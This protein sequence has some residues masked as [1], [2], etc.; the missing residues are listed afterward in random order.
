MKQVQE[1]PQ[2]ASVSSGGADRATPRPVAPL[3]LGKLNLLRVGYLVM[4]LGLVV[5]KWPLL[6][7]HA[8]WTLEQ[9][10]I[11][12]LLVGMSILA[13]LGVRYPHRMLPILLF[14]VTWKV[15][16]LGIVVLPQWANDQLDGA[17][18]AQAG[19]IAWVVVIIAVIPW[20]YVFGQFVAAPADPW[21]RQK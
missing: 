17:T 8:S 12:C 14:E 3:A 13:L 16:W 2:T 21:R 4:G 18:R 7:D 1:R 11:E 9:G 19:K 20:R 5:F 15:L 6:L 10:T